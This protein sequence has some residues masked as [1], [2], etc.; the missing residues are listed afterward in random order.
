MRAE[1][2]QEQQPLATLVLSHP[3]KRDATDGK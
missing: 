1:V 3:E 2:L